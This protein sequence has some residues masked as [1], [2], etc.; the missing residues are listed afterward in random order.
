MTLVLVLITA[1]AFLTEHGPCPREGR[2]SIRRKGLVMLENTNSPQFS[3][4]VAKVRE[5]SREGNFG[6]RGEVWVFGQAA[7]GI[8]VLIAPLIPEASSVVQ[9]IGLLCMVLSGLLIV[10]GGISLG[11]NLTPW[12]KPTESNALQT[13]GTYALCRHPLYGGLILGFG[14]LSFV[15]LS[16]ERVL[17]TLA[18]F[19]LLNSKAEVEEA[20]VCKSCKSCHARLRCEL[21]I[22]YLSAQLEEKHGQAYTT[23]AETVPRFF[24]T[25]KGLRRALMKST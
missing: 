22:P 4:F 23:W 3:R 2:T 9:I 6:T 13:T 12:P 25:I 14:G 11:D 20:M 5:N 17:F 15:S 16:V 10:T 18:L 8:C 19:I 21:T 1:T 24:P 7:L